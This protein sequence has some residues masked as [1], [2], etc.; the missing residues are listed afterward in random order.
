M[1]VDSFMIPVILPLSATGASQTL[2][3]LRR[4]AA[5]P[6]SRSRSPHS[7][8][9]GFPVKNF[10][11]IVPLLFLWSP[12]ASAQFRVGPTAG[13]TYSSLRG[14]APE[15]A[16]YGSRV[17]FAGGAVVDIHLTSDLAL[18]IQP[19]YIQKGTNIAFDLGRNEMRD[20]LELLT[21]YFNLTAL[22]KVFPDGGLTFVS[23]GLGFGSLLKAKLTD[24]NTGAKTAEVKSFFKEFDFSAIIGFGVMVHVGSSLLTFELRY[25]Q[26]ILNMV[27]PEQDPSGSGMPVRARSTGLHLFVAYLFTLCE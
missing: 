19:L 3:T 1:T 10:L 26:S 24:I 9:S 27:K 8:F 21:E 7:I 5:L 20:S 15:D 2:S 14:D 12:L 17:G 4:S 22:V 13:L 18:S 23:G 6:S 16:S 25:D 11:W